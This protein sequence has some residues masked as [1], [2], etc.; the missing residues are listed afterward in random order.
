M[1]GGVT[2][3]R[4]DDQADPVEPPTGRRPEAPSAQPHPF[5]P[6]DITDEEWIAAGQ[7]CGGLEIDRLRTIRSHC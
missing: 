4:A 7:A 5:T 6:I 2:K 3:S 1:D